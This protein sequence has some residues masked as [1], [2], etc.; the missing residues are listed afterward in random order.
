[1][2]IKDNFYK[3]IEEGKKGSNVGL[4]IGLDKLASYVDDYLPGTTYTIAAQSGVGK[5]TFA[6]YVFVFRPLMDYIN[7]EQPVDRDPYWIMFNLEMTAE[8]IFAKLVSMYIFETFGEQL[9][10]KEM[11]SRGKNVKITD[12]HLEMVKQCDSFLDILE[13][14]LIFHSSTLNSDKYVK[15]LM[16]DLELFG[17][18]KDDTYTPFNKNQIVGVFIDHLSL[19]R[20]AGGRTKKDEIDLISS[21]SV[22][23]R[24]KCSILSF[25]EI[26]Q[27]NRNANNPE[28]LKQD[29]QDPDA[30]DFKD[31]G[32]VYE[33][34]QI[35]IA[36]HSPIKFKR[37]KY[38]PY[39]IS[40]LGQV[41]IAVVVLKTRFGTSDI[42]VPVGFYG[43]CSTYK[44][45]P[46]AN[47]IYDYEKYKNPYWDLCKEDEFKK[48][49]TD[50]NKISQF[51]LT[52]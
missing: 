51:T 50:S 23:F 39:D 4:S 34:S 42:S 7:N 35:V 24:N 46:K 37:N 21:Y 15:I 49:D 3:L 17:T 10:Y 8:Q 36:L 18:F 2:S 45:L 31:S 33:D 20:S 38:G 41:F 44:E 5:S 52:L 22:G 28:R 9:T 13:K 16:K 12:E 14:R 25:I 32:A 30:S 40:I 27:F 43:D 1:M 29:K 6:L 26:M 48:Q 47:E 11:F 19:I